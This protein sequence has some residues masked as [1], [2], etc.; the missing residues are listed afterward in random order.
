MPSRKKVP[1]EYVVEALLEKKKK[2]NGQIEYLVKWE[3]YSD[4]E[5]NTWEPVGNLQCPRLLK[6][7]EAKHAKKK[8]EKKIQPSKRAL[9]QEVKAPSTKKRV[10]TPLK[11]ISPKRSRVSELPTILGS[12][13]G[14]GFAD[15]GIRTYD[16]EGILD[17]RFY[18]TTKVTEFL[19]KSHSILLVYVYSFLK[20]SL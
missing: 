12:P 13:G 5:D 17:E 11:Q 9:Q 14:G 18:R 7:F 2:R 16:V 10:A 1:E 19:V 15:A 4:E 3:G 6:E 8:T 20:S